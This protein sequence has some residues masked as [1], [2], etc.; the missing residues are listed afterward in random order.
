[1]RDDFDE[2]TVSAVAIHGRPDAPSATE[3]I[4]PSDGR[5]GIVLFLALTFGLMAER[6]SPLS[7]QI[8]AGT[9]F[10]WLFIA[11]YHK[12]PAGGRPLLMSCLLVGFF[13]EIFCSLIWGI[14]DYRL[15]NI[16]HY[17]PP[18]HVLVFLLGNILAPRLPK[19]IVWGVPLLATPYV[20]AGYVAGFDQFGAILMAMFFACLLA[21]KDRRL[22][23]TM[24]LLCLA[25]E[26]YGTWLGNWRWKPV[27]PIWGITTEN[28]PVGSGAFYCVLD[29]LMFRF[30]LAFGYALSCFRILSGRQQWRILDT[31]FSSSKRCERSI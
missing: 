26:F 2:G 20:L 25:L 15:F 30:A 3:T 17:V 1:M 5:T 21:E 24:F 7:G 13:G 16:P 28:P 4:L 10:W 12:T 23:S 18:G 19:G 9:L 27:V 31:I 11:F 29:F 8:F 6:I 14:Y 22:Y